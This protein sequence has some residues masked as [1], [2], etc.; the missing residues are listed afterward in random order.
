V[1]STVTGGTTVDEIMR[2]PG[3][4]EVLQRLGINHCCGGQLP[5]REAAAAAGI[6]VDEALAA[7]AAEKYA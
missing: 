7:L 3:A 5:L 6:S 4:R 2:R 1:S